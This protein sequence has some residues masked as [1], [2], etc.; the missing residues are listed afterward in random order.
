MSH[1]RKRDR[2]R[3]IRFIIILDKIDK[4]HLLALSVHVDKKYVK[5]ET[6]R[7]TKKISFNKELRD[8]KYVKQRID[9][10]IILEVYF[11]KT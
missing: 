3:E 11:K 8:T 7:I 4:F 5:V 6:S 1:A 10:N 2:K 9:N